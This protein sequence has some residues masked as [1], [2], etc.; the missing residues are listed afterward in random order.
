M[1]SWDQD[2]PLK[3][4]LQKYRLTGVKNSIDSQKSSIERE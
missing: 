4:V 3:Q 2:I 1:E